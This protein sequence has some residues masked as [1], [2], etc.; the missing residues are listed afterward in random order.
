MQLDLLFLWVLLVTYFYHKYWQLGVQGK[1]SKMFCCAMG[2]NY[3]NE[4]IEDDEKSLEELDNELHVKEMCETKTSMCFL[5]SQPIIGCP[6]LRGKFYLKCSTSAKK[7]VRY[8]SVRYIEVFLWEFDRDSVG[9]LKKCPLLP[10]VR[11][12]AR[13]L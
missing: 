8:K 6:L 5:F 7:S 11:Y 2:N 4:C 3:Y 13:P 10:G 1:K 12:K 9:S